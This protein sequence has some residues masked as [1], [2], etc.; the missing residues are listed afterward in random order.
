MISCREQYVFLLPPLVSVRRQGQPAER[1][2][3]TPFS[4]PAS[5]VVCFLL[6]REGSAVKCTGR[7]HGTQGACELSRRFSR[8]DRIAMAA[9]ESGR[10]G[11]DRNLRWP[12]LLTCFVLLCCCF[13]QVF[14]FFFF[15]FPML[16][17]HFLV[18]SGP[19]E[20][21]VPLGSKHPSFSGQ[22]LLLLLFSSTCSFSVKVATSMIRQGSNQ[23]TTEYNVY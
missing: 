8:G 6:G 20:L 18:Q 10:G 7:V 9:G 5:H 15:S 1:S 3:L 13:C 16:S 21:V 12:D 2:F 17:C 19:C 23:G 4:S 22:L 14:F 11:R